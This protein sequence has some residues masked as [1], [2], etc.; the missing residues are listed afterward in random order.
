M[1]IKTMPLCHNRDNMLRHNVAK[2]QK[3]VMRQK[4]RYHAIALAALIY[5]PVGLAFP[6]PSGTTLVM[7]AAAECGRVR[8]K[9]PAVNRVR[10]ERKHP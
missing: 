7:H 10:S 9:G 2:R 4:C 8:C 3:G 6:N 1:T 5:L